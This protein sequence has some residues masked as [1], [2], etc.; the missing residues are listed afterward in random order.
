[1]RH[2][3]GLSPQTIADYLRSVA[4]CYEHVDAQLGCDPDDFFESGGRL[5][6]GEIDALLSFLRTRVEESEVKRIRPRDIPTLSTLGK[7]AGPVRRFLTWAAD[8]MLRGGRTFVPVDELTAYALRLETLFGPV[9]RNRSR[10]DRIQPLDDF[11]D[12]LLELVGPIRDDSGRFVLPYRF[13][14]DN[15]FAPETRLR[16]WLMIQ[17]VL[18]VGF[19]RGEILKLRIDDVVPNPAAV[20]VVRRPHDPTD[21][22]KLKPSVKTW[23]KVAPLSPLLIGWLRMYQTTKPPVGRKGIGTPYLFVSQAGRP[24]SIR[25]MAKV[26]ESVR[27]S[28]EANADVEAVRQRILGVLPNHQ[29]LESSLAEFANATIA[30]HEAAVR[31]GGAGDTEAA[32]AEYALNLGVKFAQQQL[33]L[34]RLIAADAVLQAKLD[35]LRVPSDAVEDE[36]RIVQEGGSAEVRR[37]FWTEPATDDSDAVQHTFRVVFLNGSAAILKVT[38]AY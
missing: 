11:G 33:W 37:R 8:P 29:G 6:G 27:E 16:N 25:A 7:V 35:E 30:A 1:M 28:I 14:P 24:L 22:R 19:R 5:D 12:G 4:L 3:R 18:E 21:T 32:L 2:L 36:W 13:R 23:E 15:P 20:K 26:L 9:E 10:G 34:C 31:L 17:M 38:D